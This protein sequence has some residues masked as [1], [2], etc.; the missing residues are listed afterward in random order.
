MLEIVAQGRR[1]IEVVVCLR[2]GD[3][4]LWL[5]VLEQGGCDVL[6]EPFEHEEVGESSKLPQPEAIRAPTLKR[7]AI[8]AMRHAPP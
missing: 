4:E 3:T 6:V 8:N 5:D 2:L 1:K 7:Y